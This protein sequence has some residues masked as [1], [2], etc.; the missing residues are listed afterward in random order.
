[1]D[2]TER[3]L[4]RAFRNC[5][6]AST[7]VVQTLQG[8]PGCQ[9]CPRVEMATAVTRGQ[10]RFAVHWEAT[11]HAAAT[12]MRAYH[13]S[14][15]HRGLS[16]RHGVVPRGVWRHPG[17]GVIRGRPP[18]QRGPPPHHDQVKHGQAAAGLTRQDLSW[19]RRQHR[20]V[21]GGALRC[22]RP[23]RRGVHLAAL[24]DGGRPQER[25]PCGAKAAVRVAGRHI[26][27]RRPADVPAGR[28]R[29][30][31]RGR[32]QHDGGVLQGSARQRQ[33]KGAALCDGALGRGR[34]DAH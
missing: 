23:H 3:R 2:L 1:M 11:L 12:S 33:A 21:V 30:W 14:R 31:R 9:S 32:G 27:L 25:R 18:L 15:V 28:I 8:F 13:H 34:D 16:Q 29:W 17:A 7:A 22:G 5:M 6:A 4:P 19:Q 10:L 26:R 20:G 24:Q